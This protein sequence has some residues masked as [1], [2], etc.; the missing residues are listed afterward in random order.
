MNSRTTTPTNN[1]TNNID[2][3]GGSSGLVSLGC[4][5]AIYGR[6]AAVE[7]VGLFAFLVGFHDHFLPLYA[8]CR[9]WFLVLGGVIL[10]GVYN[11][12]GYNI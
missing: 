8:I 4:L 9:L 10:L 2:S 11:P 3:G 12:G 1:Q 6:P 5:G 7:A